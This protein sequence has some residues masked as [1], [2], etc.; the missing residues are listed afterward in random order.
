MFC[1][2]CSCCER[3]TCIARHRKMQPGGGFRCQGREAQEL[4]LLAC[5][6]D[7]KL[8]LHHK[9]SRGYTDLVDTSLDH[10][11]RHTAQTKPAGETL[12][13]KLMFLVINDSCC[14]YFNLRWLRSVI[15]TTACDKFERW[16]TSKSLQTPLAA[17]WFNG[18]DQ[19]HQ[20]LQAISVIK[21][22]HSYIVL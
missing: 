10:L 9:I 22:Q 12:N 4:D 21:S 18:P 7:R 13:L 8:M 6:F 20:G 16:L 2:C 3:G 17:L 14:L 11:D 1:P 19:L 15:V 5:M